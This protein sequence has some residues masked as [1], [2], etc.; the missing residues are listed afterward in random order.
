MTDQP[1]SRGP[2][3][4]LCWDYGCSHPHT[5]QDTQPQPS[6]AAIRAKIAEAAALAAEFDQKLANWNELIAEQR[7]ATTQPQPAPHLDLD[8]IQ[9]RHHLIADPAA[10]G[11]CWRAA[12]AGQPTE[13]PECAR[14]AVLLPPPDQPSDDALADLTDEQKAALP[15]RFHTPVWEGLAVPHSWVCAVCYGDGWTTAWP[16][17]TALQHGEFVFTPEHQADRARQDVPALI[18]RVR[19]LE[20]RTTKA[21]ADLTEMT[22]CRDN[23]IRAL[24]RDDIDTDLDIED[25][26]ANE[27]AGQG[28]DWEDD[29]APRNIAE[30]LAPAIRPALAKATQQR[31]QALARVRELEQ[32]L[33]AVRAVCDQAEHQAT[34][35]QDPL[36]VPGWV[37]DVRAALDDASSGP[38][39]PR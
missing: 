32:Q 13:H 12:R 30:L 21:D 7:S 4:K 3:C 39:A 20:A 19:H 26:I 38:A 15:A 35:W 27:L 10:C 5:G 16:C 28:W 23:A 14:R 25:V 24:R 2:Y 17:K 29:D 6:L 34:R 36:P 22:H 8:T 18:A 1:A 9:A 31:D 33:A 37:S 11:T